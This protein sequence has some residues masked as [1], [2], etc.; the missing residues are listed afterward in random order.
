MINTLSS[1]SISNIP[2]FPPRLREAIEEL[3]VAGQVIWNAVIYDDPQRTATALEFAAELAQQ[4]INAA[5]ALLREPEPHPCTGFFRLSRDGD[6]PPE[7]VECRECGQGCSGGVWYA[8]IA[9]GLYGPLCDLCAS[10]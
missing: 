3:L 1:V 6:A 7:E 5:L 10:K 8:V 9:E 4:S 2:D